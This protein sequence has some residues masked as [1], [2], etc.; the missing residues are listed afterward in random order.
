MRAAAWKSSPSAGAA[1]GE[2]LGRGDT[3]GRDREHHP[4]AELARELHR[5]RAEGRDVERDARLE[6]HVLLLADEHLD[7]ARGA[8]RPVV[9]RLAPQQT[10]QHPQV[11][12]VLR[13]AHRG[14]AHAA[15][16]GVAGADAQ[17]HAAGGEPVEG[18]H[19]GHVHRRDAGAAD[20]DPGP[21]ADAAS[22]LRGQ[23]QH[24]VAVGEQHLA[25]G[26][27][28]RVVAQGFGVAEEADLVDVGHHAD[29]EAHVGSLAGSGQLLSRIDSSI[30]LARGTS[31]RVQRGRSVG[32]FSFRTDWSCWRASA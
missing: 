20:R 16:G 5:P 13:D 19:R 21:Q 22:L 2:G 29:G 27:P 23:R 6:A 31:L 8:G 1:P 10:A 32:A 28:H 18:G 30:C 25:V 17:V 14:L 11:L 26:H 3:A 7:R 4:V 12:G 9:H 24:R 15:G